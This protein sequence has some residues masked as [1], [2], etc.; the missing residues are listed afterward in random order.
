MLN[1]I[2]KKSLIGLLL[3]LTLPSYVIAAEDNYSSQLVNKSNQ[4][5]SNGYKLVRTK[6][7][8]SSG[9]IIESGKEIVNPGESTELKIKKKKECNES[10]IG[11]SM[12]KIEDSKNAHLLGYVSHR[13]GEG[14]FS[15]QISRFC[16]G[17][18]CVFTDLDPEQ[19]RG[20]EK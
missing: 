16:H 3:V 12:Y 18:Q 14:K 9:C 6:L 4:L 19:A 8:P 11:Y 2:Q 1:I 13:L 20:K 10:G 5:G 17:S 15:L 7:W